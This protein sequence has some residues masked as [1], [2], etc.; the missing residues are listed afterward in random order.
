M[1][2]T[3]KWENSAHTVIRCE[4]DVSWTWNDVFAMKREIESMMDTAE[5][6]VTVLIQM[7]GKAFP[8]SGTLTYTKHLFIHNHPKYANHV[9]FVGGSVLIKTF[10]RI[11]R[12]AYVQS[13]CNIQSDYVDTLDG[14]HHLLDY[15]NGNGA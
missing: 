3:V 6:P 12:K 9:I 14:A 5:Q 11:I 7:H 8:E 15:K 4:F 2:I 1:A 13:M 10:E